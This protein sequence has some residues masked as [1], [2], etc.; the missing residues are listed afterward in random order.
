MFQRIQTVYLILALILMSLLYFLPLASLVCGGVANVD[1]YV[2]GI[3][4]GMIPNVETPIVW[5]NITIV[6]LIITLLL[7]TIVKYKKRMMQIR[8]CFLNIVLMLG[9]VFLFWYNIGEQT[10][11]LKAVMTYS[12]P[13][14]FPFIAVILT[15]LAVRGIGKD[16]A[17]IRSMDSI[18]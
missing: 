13:M 7:L 15:Y 16:E 1:F 18:R 2:Y 12:M 8:L 5:T 4:K 11:I 14:I 17:L 10:E 6:S 9:S 3:P